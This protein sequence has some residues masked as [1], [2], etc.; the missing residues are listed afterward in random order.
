MGP[1]M[2]CRNLDFSIDQCEVGAWSMTTR[3]S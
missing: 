3:L 1:A 2:I